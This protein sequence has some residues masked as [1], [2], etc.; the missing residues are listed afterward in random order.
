MAD[1][2]RKT[3]TS[4]DI[5]NQGGLMDVSFNSYTGKVKTTRGPCVLLSHQECRKPEEKNQSPCRTHLTRA[6]LPQWLPGGRWNHRRNRKWHCLRW[7]RERGNTLLLCS[8]IGDFGE[9]TLLEPD[10]CGSLAMHLS[11]WR[12]SRPSKVRERKPWESKRANSTGVL[13]EGNTRKG[14]LN[15]VSQGLLGSS[16]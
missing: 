9:P 7:G 12:W 11:G 10:W 4:Q 6:T 3:E 2:I 16:S 14:I 5:S 15:Q 13:G 1:R 8:L